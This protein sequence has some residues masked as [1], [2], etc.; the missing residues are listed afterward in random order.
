MSTFRTSACVTYA[1][2]AERRG[3]CDPAVRPMRARAP[4]MIGRTLAFGRRD[5][6]RQ[7]ARPRAYLAA[8]VWNTSFGT[9]R[10]RSIILTTP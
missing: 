6:P 3:N 7:T 4:L 10:S 2:L 8:I 1:R 9:Q 5:D